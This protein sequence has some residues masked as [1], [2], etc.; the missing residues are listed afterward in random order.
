MMKIKPTEEQKRFVEAYLKKSG[1]IANRGKFDGHISQQKAGFLAQIVV[2]DLLNLP[3][4]K[5]EGFDSGIDFWLGGKSF[6]VKCEIRNVA[7]RPEEFVH[8]LTGLQI[9]YDVDYYV[10][11]S[12]NKRKDE[13]EICGWIRKEL[14]KSESQFYKEGTI[15]KRTDGTEFSTKADLWEIKDWC[16]MPFE[17]LLKIN[18]VLNGRETQ[19]S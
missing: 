3:R 19:E 17:T 16:L 14:F 7:F 15:R 11:V 6:D 13:F 18:G 10:F 2:T 9:K 1:G 8:N 12:Y 4:P 5:N